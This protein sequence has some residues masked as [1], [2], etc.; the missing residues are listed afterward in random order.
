[1]A[2]L[3]AATLALWPVGY[4]WA[5]PGEEPWAWVAGFTIGVAPLVLRWPAA[6]LTGAGLAAAAVVGALVGDQSGR[7]EPG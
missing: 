5:E 1:M 3:V 4:A 2:G 7:A 6:L